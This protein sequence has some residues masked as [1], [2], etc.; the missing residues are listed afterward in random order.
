MILTPDEIIVVK[1]SLA[2]AVKHG[3]L[4]AEHLKKLLKLA[5]S[6][7]ES[8]PEAPERLYTVQEAAARLSCHPKSIFRYIREGRLTAIHIGQRGT[9]IAD[10]EIQHFISN[11]T[12]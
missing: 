6:D 9:R 3:L 7:G 8:R 12:K 5:A 11:N 2:V 4:D 1:D 10:S